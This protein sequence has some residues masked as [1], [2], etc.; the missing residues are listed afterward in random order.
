MKFPTGSIKKWVD[1]EKLFL[2][3]FFEDDIEISVPTPL[4]TKQKKGESIEAFVERFRSMALWCSIGMTQ[5]K[6][7]ETYRHNLQITLL[8]Q[9]GIAQSRTWKQLILQGE[10]AEDIVARLSQKD[11]KIM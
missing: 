2:V 7:V 4:A 6:L 3:W 11:Y 8:A 9:I 5:Y 1:L 10:R